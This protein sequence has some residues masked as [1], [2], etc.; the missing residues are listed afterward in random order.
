MSCKK[1]YVA[2]TRQHVGKTTSTLGLVSALQEAGHNVGYSKPV[3]QKFI[4]LGK[5]RVDKDA[6][7]FSKF[8]KFKLDPDI[9][10]PVIL[11][12]GATTAY[13]DNPHDFN[14]REAIENAKEVLEDRHDIIVYEGTGHPGVG[15]IVNLSNAD[16]AKML[17][18]PVIMIAEG[19]VGN[20]IDKLNMTLALFRE[21][22]V[23]VLGVIIN[24]VIP[25]KLEMVRH[26]LGIKLKEM[27]LPLLGI[28]PYDKTLM[29]P[30]MATVRRA[31]RGKVL[32]NEDFLNNRVE[33][34]LPASL[35][36]PEKIDH[37][38]N[39]LLV[40]SI[41]RIDKAI[42]EIKRV[43]NRKNLKC[44][45]ISGIILTG[46]DSIEEYYQEFFTE[47]DYIKEQEIPVMTTQFDTLGAVIKIN[48]IEVKINIRTPWKSEKAVQL[49][50]DHVDLDQLIKML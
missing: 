49:I 26:Y 45:P 9:H 18:A 1:V 29:Y 6:L 41:K 35:I 7:L 3:G 39:I 42:K 33:E 25:E 4:D 21:Q 23:K 40:S 31:I 28:L 14:Y 16:V 15:S 27:G 34:I 11:G 38:A 37:F 2:A 32:F 5:L 43:A 8:S 10:S 44:L 22:N 48:R 13:L 17:D 19:G 30:I 36:E 46:E 20:T 12:K 47:A 50:K 24:K